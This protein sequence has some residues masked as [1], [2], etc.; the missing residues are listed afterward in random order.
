MPREQLV[1]FSSTLEERIPV[2]HPV[3]LLDEILDE[4]LDQLDWTDWEAAYV[5]TLG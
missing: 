3:R 4:I 5:G 2:D 1:L